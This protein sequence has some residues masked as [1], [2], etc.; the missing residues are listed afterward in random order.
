[1]LG[2]H[3]GGSS[4]SVR[5]PAFAA[6]HWARRKLGA[7][8]S[9][10]RPGAWGSLSAALGQM[11]MAAAAAVSLITIG[12]A[13]P[14][15]CDESI[16]LTDELEGPPLASHLECSLPSLGSLSLS[17]SLPLARPLAR[18]LARLLACSLS[19]QASGRRE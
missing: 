16:N 4:A 3:R 2:G 6:A 15:D 5:P 8:S 7:S 14:G 10:V 12:P 18:S 19:P 17:L 1:M 9:A 13:Q 11:M